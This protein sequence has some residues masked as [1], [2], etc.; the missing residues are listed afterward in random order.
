MI[1]RN[2]SL[3][4]NKQE[5]VLIEM[6]DNT[7]VD[8]KNTRSIVSKDICEKLGITKENLYHYI[9]KFNEK[10]ERVDKIEDQLINRKKEIESEISSLE[11]E[12]ID[13]E[14]ELKYV[15][16]LKDFNKIRFT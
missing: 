4:T 12:M 10:S 6:I 8:G 15:K 5:V 14:I 7:K 11:E 9:K 13:V 2:Y 3:L 16:Y 1:E